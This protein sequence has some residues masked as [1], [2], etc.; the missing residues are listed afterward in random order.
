M[1]GKLAELEV[2]A[3]GHDVLKGHTFTVEIPLQ[4]PNREGF[5]RWEW[6]LRDVTGVGIDQLWCWINVVQA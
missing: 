2:C 6:W 4:A 3:S 1:F 5:A